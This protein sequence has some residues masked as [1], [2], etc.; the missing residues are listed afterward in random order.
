MFIKIHLKIRE[1]KRLKEREW[2]RERAIEGG[3]KKKNG[4][5]D[6]VREEEGRRV[7]GRLITTAN[8]GTQD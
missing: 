3:E 6:R 4:K 7:G 5:E 1:E 2:G 8:W